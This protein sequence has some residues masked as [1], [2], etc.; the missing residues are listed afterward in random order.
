MSNITLSETEDYSITAEPR[1]GVVFLHCSIHN[2][3][4]SVLKRVK[5]EFEVIY[6]EFQDNNGPSLFAYYHNL[7]FIDFLGIPYEV[8]PVEGHEDDEEVL[9]AW[10][11]GQQ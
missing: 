2:P 5:D 11:H 7:K 6:Q 3:K 1:E 4:K 8:V 9:V 10:Q